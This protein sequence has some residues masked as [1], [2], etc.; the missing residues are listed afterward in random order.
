MARQPRRLAR[1]GATDIPNAAA[2]DTYVGPSGELVA[3]HAR[4]ILALQDGAT[5]GGKRFNAGV[6]IPS[7]GTSGQVLAKLS[8][9]DG[10]VGWVNQSGGGGG[11]V[12]EITLLDTRF[13]MLMTSKAVG[14]VLFGGAGG[15]AIHDGFIT[16][17]YV[18]VPG[19]TN[20]N[21]AEQGKLKPARET[22]TSADP[23]ATSGIGT[24]TMF[25]RGISLDNGKTIK[26]IGVYSGTAGPLT[27]KIALRNSTT[28]YTV[29]LSEA[30]THP[31]TGWVD[32]EL[33]TPFDVPAS[34][35]YHIGV[36]GPSSNYPVVTGQPRAY[37]SGNAALGNITVNEQS[38]DNTWAVRAGYDTLMDAT[39][40]SYP[41]VASAVP[42]TL[43]GLFLLESP[44][45]AV[46][47]TDVFLDVS[48]NGGAN[49][50][51]PTLSV[52]Y[53]QPGNI[54]VVSTGV[55]DVSGQPSGSSIMWRW[56]TDNG[57]DVKMNGITLW[58]GAA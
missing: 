57:V 25:N 38:A 26:T 3:D 36:H 21:A 18:D 5:P 42:A 43:R 1:V 41:I 55:V 45:G 51:T 30:V 11:G 35:T 32:F 19:A 48:R 14:S 39:V 31:G 2:F 27:L 46:L 10:H 6:A 53:E 56:R 8:N 12:S 15:E 50:S 28:S 34:G 23:N 16:L 47:N 44:D 13:T 9:T 58:T 24:L 37:V 4:G 33:D 17:D 20:L 52:L 54:L 7:G 40:S 49:W 29:V 22:E